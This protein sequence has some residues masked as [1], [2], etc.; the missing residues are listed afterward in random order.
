MRC[1]V[2][3]D[4]QEPQLLVGLHVSQNDVIGRLR[5]MQGQNSS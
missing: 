3:E 5:L 2:P 4:M 1:T